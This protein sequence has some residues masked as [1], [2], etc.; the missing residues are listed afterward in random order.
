MC[1]SD[2]IG[3]FFKSL[4][5]P[6]IKPGSIEHSSVNKLTKLWTIFALQGDPNAK[7]NSLL[8]FKWKAAK[9]KHIYYLKINRE[10]SL[11]E[12]PEMERMNFWDEL[13]NSYSEVIQM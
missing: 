10:W 9:K 2:E 3:Y 12:N 5:T 7:K 13:F 1:H 8:P 11:D 6:T 4:L